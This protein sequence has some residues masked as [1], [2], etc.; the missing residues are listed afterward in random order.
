MIAGPG[1]IPDSK[2]IQTVLLRVLAVI[3]VVREPDFF[4][5]R[6]RSIIELP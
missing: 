3:L 1:G 4:L 2:V 5:R 6:E